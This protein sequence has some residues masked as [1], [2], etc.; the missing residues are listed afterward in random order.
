MKD[1]KLP[2]LGPEIRLLVDRVRAVWRI[3]P[4]VHKHALGAA[5]VVM[6]VT[7][8]CNTAM[9]LLLGRL[10][11]QIKAGTE[12]GL[13]RQTLFVTAGTILGL[14]GLAYLFREGLNVL[15]RYLVENT[16]TRIQRDMTVKLVGHMMKV[17]MTVL[18]RDR[19]GTLNGRIFRSVDG[20]VRFLR[21]SFLDFFPA[22]MTGLFALG[23]TLTKQPLLGLA[24]AGVI[25]TT[26]WLTVR[27]LISQKGVR[28]KL[29][30]SHEEID[31]AV[32]ERLGGIEYIRAANMNGHEERR[33]RSACESRRRTEIRHHVRMSMFGCAKA[34]NEGFFH[35]LVLGSAITLA[36]LRPDQVSFGDVLTFSILFLSVMSPLSEVHRVLDE[37]HEAS[38]SVGDLLK[39]LAEPWDRSFRVENPG[40]PQAIP[41]APLIVFD[42]VR[43]EY[44]TPDGKK[45]QALNDV[46]LSLSGGETIG[47]AGC[48][49]GGKSTWLKVLLRL[50]HPSAG[51][52][53]VGGVHLERLSREHIGQ[54]I[55]YVGQAPF[56]FAGTIAE[57]IAYGNGSPAREEIQGA[58]QRAH[59]HDEILLMP[60]GYDSPITERGMNLSGG[61]RQ[62]LALAR[63]LLKQPP[64]LILDEATSALDNISERFVHQQLG[65][66]RAERTTI[67]VAHRLTTLRDADRIVVFDDGRIVEI[68]TYDAL[69]RKG[70]VFNEL[71]M[72]AQS[73]SPEEVGLVAGSSAGNG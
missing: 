50:T 52:V 48:S 7:S 14:I 59:L 57:N 41:G 16:C 1:A 65:L 9:P 20:F 26:V 56:V 44:E 31:G 27:Q 37:G 61:Q 24:M 64:V 60:G 12:Q 4:R 39:M 71:V 66:D 51:S 3:V 63:I 49:G 5:A 22:I 11:D 42:K 34:L 68:G 55:G 2:S 8:A 45:R 40:Y 30:R 19:V 18:S 23:A 47:I 53:F 62:R 29:L 36:I 38:L 6:A 21:L 58:A 69:V 72:S 43:V 17:D 10:V 35:I 25:P 70:G 32:V 13:P 67:L 33:I 15:R 73:A 54:L 28:L 46:S